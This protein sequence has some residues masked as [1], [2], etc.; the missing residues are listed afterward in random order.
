MNVQYITDSKGETTGVFIPISDW[1][2]LKSKYG[3]FNEES[4]IPEFHKEIVRSR[5]SEYENNP[6]I[7][8]DFDSVLVDLEND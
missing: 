3:E 6:A 2:G 5:I 8:L 4:V 7:G 1:I